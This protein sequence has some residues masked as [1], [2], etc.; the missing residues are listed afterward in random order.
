MNPPTLPSLALFALLLVTPVSAAPLALYVSPHGHDNAP[1]GRAS[2]LA[3]LAGARDRLRALKSVGRMPKEGATVWIRGGTYFQASTFTL[4]AADDV[5]PAPVTYA[6]WGG[7]TVR[8]TGGREVT[9]WKPVTDLTITGRLHPAARS[10]VLV[11]DL[12]AQNITDYGQ[13]TP[14]GF[15]SPVTPAG[16]ELFFQD[17]PMTLARWPNAGKWAHVVGAAADQ[18]TDHFSYDGDRPQRWA[19]AEDAWVYGYWKFDWADSYTKITGIDTAQHLI[20]TAPSTDLLSPTVGHRWYALNLLEELDT[21]G[22]WYLDRQGGRLYFWPPSDIRTGRPMVSLTRDLVHLD[23]VSHVTL[24]GLTFEDCRGDAVTIRNGGHDLIEGCTL[25]NTGN[26]GATIA[27]S[28][29]SGVSGGEITQTGEGGI[30]ID[31]GDRKTLTQGRNFVE[32]C[33]IHDYSRWARTYRPGV[34][35]D[36]VGNRISHNLIY[37]APHNAILLGGNDHLIEY[38]EVHHVCRETGDSGAFYMGRDWTMRGDVVRF[39]YFHD[40]TNETGVKGEFHDVMG[41]YLDDTAAGAVIFGNVFVRAGHA[42]EIGGGRDITVENNVFVDCHPAVSLD[43][44][45]LNWAAKSLAPGGGWG[46]EKRLAAV[47]YN[48]P[49]YSA[50]YPHLAGILKDD[51]D[52]PKYDVIANNVASRCPDWLQ[53]QNKADTLPGIT[54]K[55]NLTDQNPTFLAIQNDLTE[56]DHVFVDSARGDYR[57]KGGAQ[58]FAP[59]YKRVPFAKMGLEPTP[60]RAPTL[61]E[62]EGGLRR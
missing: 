15:G 51:P 26:R 50:R 45:G 40:L 61:P 58:P 53:I 3:T 59:G 55:D 41:V 36:G 20:R 17:A 21:P 57:L 29:D 30:S 54:I 37:D 11:S 42:I 19:K 24:R 49:L 6:G 52:A 56:K 38:N 46:M 2:P 13:M 60:A 48:G 31:G 8:V 32:N 34:G 9:G 22:E 25:R 10:H 23:G 16:L 7:E 62:R 5:S 4:S 47:P 27:A 1:G 33:R 43:A 39:N 14:R 35:I 12:K 28:T 44:R 18:G